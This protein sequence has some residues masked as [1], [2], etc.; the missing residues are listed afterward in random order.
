MIPRCPRPAGRR[1][2][3]LAPFAALLCGSVALASFAGGLPDVSAQI[4]WE[5]AERNEDPEGGYVLYKCRQPSSGFD[6]YRLEAEIDA[7]ASVVAEAARHNIFDL[8]LV[9]DNV[10]KTVLRTQDEVAWIYSYIDLP[11]VVRDRDVITRS[12]RSYDARTGVYRLEWSASNEGPAPRR[13]VVR[14][15]QSSGSWVFSPLGNGRTR[16]VYENFTDIGGS[17]PAWIANPM[18]DSTVTQSIIDLRQ[19]V[20]D[21]QRRAAAAAASS[22]LRKGQDSALADPPGSF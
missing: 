13:G 5:V 21:Q 16:A 4:P 7:P 18:M 14:M 20:E 11:M 22:S 8:D 15:P 19:T 9:P 17:L 2:R 12:E 10:Q 1:A 3:G 6:A